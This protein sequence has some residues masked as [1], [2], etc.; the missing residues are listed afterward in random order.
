MII[1]FAGFSLRPEQG[2]HPAPGQGHVLRGGPQVEEYLPCGDLKQHQDQDLWGGVGL[3][4]KT[5]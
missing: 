2:Q 1:L 5:F 4:R 3:Y